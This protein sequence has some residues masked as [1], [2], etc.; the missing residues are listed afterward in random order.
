MQNK[1]KSKAIKKAKQHKKQKTNHQ[2]FS[3]NGTFI[4]TL[5]PA[6]RK[7]ETTEANKRVKSGNDQISKAINKNIEKTMMDRAITSKETFKYLK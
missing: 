3:K 7:E 6:A 5:E 4:L 1:K 2:K